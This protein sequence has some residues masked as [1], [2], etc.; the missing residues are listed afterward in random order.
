MTNT[1]STPRAHNDGG[2][3]T[4]IAFAETR[5]HW[6]IAIT[7]WTTYRNEV[8]YEVKRVSDDNRAVRLHHFATEAEARAYANKMWRRDR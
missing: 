8:R 5:N 7:R 1:E 6:G 3:Y 2:T 4:V